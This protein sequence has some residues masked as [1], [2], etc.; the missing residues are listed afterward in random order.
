MRRRETGDES[1]EEVD[2]TVRRSADEGKGRFWPFCMIVTQFIHTTNISEVAFDAC[3][4][5]VTYN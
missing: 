3:S 1:E 2:Q 5:R 4:S